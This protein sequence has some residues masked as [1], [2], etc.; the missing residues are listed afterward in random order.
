ME[1]WYKKSD[2]EFINLDLV[3]RVEIKIGTGLR[4][5]HAANFQSV[6]REPAPPT[7]TLHLAGGGTVDIKGGDLIN[8]TAGYLKLPGSNDPQSS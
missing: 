5:V 1:K 8:Q 6:Q 2:R 7:M 4:E 3:V